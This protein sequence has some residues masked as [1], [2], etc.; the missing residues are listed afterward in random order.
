MA[1]VMI[2]LQVPGL[3]RNAWMYAWG[4]QETC[5]TCQ[6][7]I[8]KATKLEI[9]SF[10]PL[11][12]LYHISPNSTRNSRISSTQKSGASS[13]SWFA[14]FFDEKSTSGYMEVS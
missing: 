2:W 3:P 11:T 13:E 12:I 7:G 6:E 10:W 5:Q 4:W 14:N 9:G 1:P 8:K